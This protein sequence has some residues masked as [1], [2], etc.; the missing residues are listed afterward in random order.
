MKEQPKRLETNLG[1]PDA[2][3][4]IEKVF[5]SSN[6]L[7]KISMGV[8]LRNAEG[9]IID[10]NRAAESILEASR[11]VL[12]GKTSTE[13][14][15]DALTLDGSPYNAQLSLDS[16]RSGENLSG[17][18]V[19]VLVGNKARKWLSLKFWPSIVNGEVVGVVTAFDDVTRIVKERRLMGLMA[20]INRVTVL[21]ISEETAM[22]RICDLVV[23]EGHYALAWI[24]VASTEGGVDIVSSSGV[25]EY[26]YEGIVSW[27]GSSQSGLGPTG[28]ALRTTTTQVADNFAT[29]PL[30]SPW[31]ER[32]ADFGLASG[33]SLPLQL[34]GRKAAISIYDKSTGAFD[35]DTVRGLEEVAREISLCIS[36]AS[37][38]RERDEALEESI[39]TVSALEQAK[40]SLSKS[41]QW[42]RTLVAKSSDL[43]IVVDDQARFSYAN[44]VVDRLFGYEPNSLIGRNI[45]D[46]I[47]PDDRA[48]AGSAVS[49]TLE[50]S[51]PD[52]PVVVRFLCSS[53][54]WRFIEGILTNCLLDEAIHGVVGNGRD[55]TERIY[56]TRALQTLSAGNQVLVHAN[57]E[58]SLIRDICHAAVDAGGYPLAWVGYLQHDDDKSIKLEAAAGV[59]DMLIDSHFSWGDGGPSQGPVGTT[60]R[61][62]EARVVN[63][64]LATEIIPPFR[65][66]RIEQY[67]LRSICTFPLQVQNE[68]I[69]V[70]AIYS[71]KPN[72]FGPNEVETLNE[73]AAELAYGISRLRDKEQLERNEDL[74]RSSDERFRLAFEHN[75][76][77]ML[78]SDFEDRVI[79][80]NDSFCRL[81]GFSREELLGHDSKQFTYPDDV[82]INEDTLARLSTEQVDQAR[83][84]KRYL[85]KDG[86]IVI[87]EISRSA[88]RD[89]SGKILYFVS[90]ERDITEERALADQLSHQALHDSLTG[91]ANRA[92]F[93]DRLA[94]AH[95]RVARQ[96]GLGAVL[97]LDLDDFK[98]VNDAHGHLVGDQL[99][100]GVARRFELVTRNTD[101]LSRFGGDEF[102]YLAE[103]LKT[104]E[105]AEEVASRL[106]D[107]LSEPFT[108]NGLSLDQHAS[109]GIVV[110][111]ETCQDSS[112]LIQKA[113]VALYEAKRLNRGRFALFTPSMHQEAVSHFELIQQ[114][115][116]ALQ[117]GD[118]SMHYQPIINLDSLEIMG[119]EALMR[120]RHPERGWVPPDV[121]IPLAEKSELILELGAF[122]LSEAVEAASSWFV[123]PGSPLPYVAVNL[124][125][126][127]SHD[128]DLIGIIEAALAKS[129]L[130]P[131]RLVL[132][133]TESAML[134]NV[135]ETLNVMERISA[136]GVGFALDDFGTG[137]SSLSYLAL[138]RPT[139]IKIDRSFVS[140]T[141]ESVRNDTLLEA[142]ISLGQ[143]LGMTMSAEGIETDAQLERLHRLGCDFGQG[144]LWSSAVPSEEVH[145]MLRRLVRV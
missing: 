120:W 114:L 92:L 124:S 60:A 139:I 117:V 25:S 46:L 105:E 64:I 17:V 23:E 7:D 86:R 132:E 31:K 27:W 66:I 119:F 76:A 144:F 81:V 99:L 47:H 134:F 61:T 70:L 53:G 71:D 45:F 94:Q 59:T 131:E 24:G 89:A 13:L 34:A 137:Y 79:A 72:Y 14:E 84:V 127:Q 142:I 138:L 56:L 78:F 3:F 12:I 4:P 33:I 73:L 113:D 145:G 130:A 6:F 140:H 37:S 11:E 26:L 44:P 36:N 102:L 77:P 82:G 110:W 74:V 16:L 22:Q 115:R 65:R 95:A 50:Q 116:R 8:H 19:G 9:V 88:A 55:I 35:D 52:Q 97:L 85:R 136:M 100:T 62:G 51:E 128:P 125:A 29:Q 135:S 75:M 18:V 68:T 21:K 42:F 111:D 15:I 109:V 93:E 107:V 28:T 69:G 104:V 83:Y 48:L 112:E 121:F 2:V 118:L 96:G 38:I 91:L 106:I 133:I 32:A 141:E 126:H 143:K 39:D 30:Y 41:E 49:A 101:T 57:D 10:C 90:S 5:S 122:A 103:G 40:L 43:I 129:G 123:A 1:G 80:V 87:S 108:F 58:A 54:E 20:A 98:G 67:G 63:D